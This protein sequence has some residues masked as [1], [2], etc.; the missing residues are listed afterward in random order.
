M[1]KFEI[2]LVKNNKLI[3]LTI[4]EKGA[5][6]SGGKTYDEDFSIDAHNKRSLSFKARQYDE[7]GNIDPLAFLFVH[8][9]ELKLVDK[10]Q[11]AHS[12]FIDK[13]AYVITQR[14][15]EL[16]ITATDSFSYVL[17]KTNVGYS[18]TDDV[19][20][21]LYV[22]PSTLDTWARKIVSDCNLT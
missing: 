22:G 21:A 16:S 11:E 8:G 19:T 1:S 15:V 20:S 10:Y 12:L 4:C 2:Y 3:P 17:A 7:S 14:N 5:V 6:N 9:A 13:I 18:I